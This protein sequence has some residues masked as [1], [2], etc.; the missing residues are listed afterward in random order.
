MNQH[1]PHLP[2]LKKRKRHAGFLDYSGMRSII[3]RFTA[4]TI[5]PSTDPVT[6]SRGRMLSRTSRLTPVRDKS[7]EVRDHDFARGRWEVLIP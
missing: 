1:Q 5:D 6:P 4:T 7:G 2:F 3:N